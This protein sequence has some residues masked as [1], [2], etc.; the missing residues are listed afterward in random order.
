MSTPDLGSCSIAQSGNHS[1]LTSLAHSKEPWIIDSGASDHVKS[2]SNFFLF[3]TSCPS[4]T[5]I[6]IVDRSLSSVVGIGS[7]RVSKY[8]ILHLVFHVP[9]LKCNLLS[10]SKI[11]RDNNCVANFHSTMCQ[12]QDLSSGRTIG[13]A[14]IHEGFYYL[15]NMEYEGRQAFV[16]GVASVSVSSAREIHHRL[17]HPNFSYLKR[18]LS[19][20]FKHE[21]FVSF[22]CDICQFAKHT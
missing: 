17:A 15:N 10:I 11:T 18:L 12:F 3:Y 6:K 21:D 9:A 22:T 13:S 1:A 2:G 14:T 20:L 8:L 5:K 19:S 4:S 7:I 16:S